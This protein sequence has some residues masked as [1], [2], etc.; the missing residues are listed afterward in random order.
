MFTECQQ[1]CHLCLFLF[2]LRSV[3]RNIWKTFF[4]KSCEPWKS[5]IWAVKHPSGLPKQGSW[6]KSCE[7]NKL[8]VLGEQLWSVEIM[9]LRC[10][11][12]PKWRIY[13]SWGILDQGGGQGF[14][15][16][17]LLWSLTLLHSHVCSIAAMENG[18]SYLCI[19]P[20][21]MGKKLI[22][23]SLSRALDIMSKCSLIHRLSQ[24]KNP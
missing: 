8:L 17:V 10:L 23:N 12:R 18:L 1:L 20:E 19:S 7:N 15:D 9:L 16:C 21:D 2:L 3:C 13:I 11:W 22:M 14:G 5:N 4:I 24:V 6:A